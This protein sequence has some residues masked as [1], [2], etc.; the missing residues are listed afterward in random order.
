MRQKPTPTTTGITDAVINA[1]S[2]AKLAK[3]L[4]VSH[5]AIQQWLKQGYVPVG[6]V[7]QIEALYGVPRE[8]LLNPKYLETLSKP[9]FNSES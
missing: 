8:R 1:G 4:G 7:T 2:Q 3:E 9:N 6:R 5:Q